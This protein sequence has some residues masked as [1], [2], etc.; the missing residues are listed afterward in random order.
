[1]GLKSRLRRIEERTHSGVCQECGL[2]PQ[3]KGYIVTDGKDP[4]PH[5]PEVCPQCGVST[6]IHICVVYEDEE[7]EGSR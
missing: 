6:R 5:L 1:V 4:V 3:S 2:S 7:G